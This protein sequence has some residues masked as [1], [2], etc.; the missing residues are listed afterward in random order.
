MNRKQFIILLVVVLVL[1]AAGWIIRQHNNTS[2]QSGGQAIGEKLLPNLPVND[3]AQIHIQ[4]GA[5]DLTLA[6][7]DD[8]WRVHERGDYPADFSRIS[9]LLLKL[10]DLKVIQ[11]DEAGPSQLGRYELLP[12]GPAT[13]AGTLVEMKDAS[14]KTVASLLLGKNHMKQG[15]GNSQFGDSGPDGRYVMT[16]AAQGSVALI[17]DPLD[18]ITAAPKDWL[19]KTFFKIE[20]PK[21]I[22]A[23]FP[24]TTNSWKLVRASETNDWQL[25]DAKPGE[26]LDSTKL[27]EVV[28]PFN[29]PSFDDVAAGAAAL[30]N[31]TALTVETFDGFTYAAEIGTQA[32]GDYPLTISVS[33][34]LP[35]NGQTNLVDKLA[36][37][38]QFSNWTYQVPSYAVDPFLK[39]RNQFLV[40][41]NSSTTNA[42]PAATTSDK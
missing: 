30:T 5:G 2:W 7:K 22:T 34:N 6:R 4:S 38:K 31:A 26:K 29:S 20:N 3:I 37:E 13:G 1:G 18:T 28:S 25:A 32:D 16:G 10:A 11:S 39:M 35:V 42:P 40:E 21:S 33:A 15:G 23:T 36:T 27:G 17:S 14:G 9:D 41:T 24:A 8:R 19:D 12:P